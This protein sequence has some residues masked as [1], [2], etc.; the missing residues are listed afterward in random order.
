MNFVASL[1][2]AGLLDVSLNVFPIDVVWGDKRGWWVGKKKQIGR[3]C[4]PM[5]CGGDAGSSCQF[6]WSQW[7]DPYMVN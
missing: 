7:C 4:R 2:W 5:A 3:R 1:L 6:G